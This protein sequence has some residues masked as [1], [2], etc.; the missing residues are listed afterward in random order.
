MSLSGLIR[1]RF[2]RATPFMPDTP[3]A[4]PVDSA[5]PGERNEGARPDEGVANIRESEERFRQFAENSTDVF[6]IL[7]AKAMRLEYVN[8]VYE[9]MFGQSRA[10]LLRDRLRRLDVV[11]PDDL[12]EATSGL[13][14]ALAGKM[15]V[16]NYRVIRPTDGATRW[17]RDT[18]FPIKNER[19]EVTRVA[20]V[21]RDVTEEQENGAALAESE[22]RFRLLVEGAR[23]YAMFV[24]GLDNRISYWSAGA[25]RIFG[26][27]AEEATGQSGELIFT[28]EDRAIGREE[29]EWATAL[30][31]GC[32]NDRRWHM[33]KDGSRIW[34]D[35]I[36]RRLDDEAGNLRGFA[37]VARNLTEE[38]EAEERLKRSY[39][40]LGRR[41]EERTADLRAM[42]EKLEA[43]LAERAE[44]EQE[45]LRVSEREKRLIGQELHDSL[46][47]ELAATAFFLESKAQSLKKGRTAEAK[48]LSEAARTVNLNV[49]LARDLARGLYPVELATSGL[50]DALRDLVFRTASKEVEC[51]FVYPK[52]IRVKDE[53]TALGLYRIAQE[54]LS[55]AIKNGRAK[56][57]CIGLERQKRGLTLFVRDDGVGFSTGKP[58][59][60]MGIHIMKYRAQSLAGTLEVESEK[61]RGTTITCAVPAT[62]CSTPSSDLP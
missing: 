10:L 13:K 47:Q 6:W 59:K 7:D 37:K 31:E 19:G 16:R 2:R 27:T 12:E 56:K 1:F 39:E 49:G 50:S 46:C 42:N 61:G 9:Q 36:M 55:N 58:T 48:T 35:G 3:A 40:D 30:R 53:A 17:I 51:Q 25:E 44:V 41:V 34:I 14:V 18:G 24:I 20:G 21:A 15:F 23:D 54:A 52:P 26:W 4:D 43:A 60:G 38:R 32:A 8:P 11:H 62:K 5:T 29:K 28:P 33:R 22:E 57:I 45:L